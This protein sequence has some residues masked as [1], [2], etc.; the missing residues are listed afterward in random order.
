MFFY[1][2]LGKLASVR[3]GFMR[4]GM[5][6]KLFFFS[7]CSDP[8]NKSILYSIILDVKCNVKCNGPQTPFLLSMWGVLWAEPAN[9]PPPAG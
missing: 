6:I 1:M 8:L 2:D 3:V 9:T 5:L 7:G 4:R